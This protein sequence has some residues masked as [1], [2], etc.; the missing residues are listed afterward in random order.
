MLW[1]VKLSFVDE[2]RL[3]RDTRCLTYQADYIR[4]SRACLLARLQWGTLLR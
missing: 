1:F 4:P 3:H 2:P